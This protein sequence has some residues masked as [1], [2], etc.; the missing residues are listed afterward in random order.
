MVYASQNGSLGH[1]CRPWKVVATALEVQPR[2]SRRFSHLRALSNIPQHSLSSGQ[3]RLFCALEIRRLSGLGQYNTPNSANLQC[4]STNNSVHSI[5][6]HKCYSNRHRPVNKATCLIH[7]AMWT[8]S[9]S[10]LPAAA[11]VLPMMSDPAPLLANALAPSL[12]PDQDPG[13]DPALALRVLALPTTLLPGLLLQ[14][15]HKSRSAGAVRVP[16]MKAKRESPCL[17]QCLAEERMTT[18]GS[19]QRRLRPFLTCILWLPHHVYSLA[20]LFQFRSR[21]PRLSGLRCDGRI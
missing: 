17:F 7:T 6:T 1:P 16:K 9:S 11:V 4:N 8:T 5:P 14:R 18:Q 12:G 2:S 10:L 21:F 20:P 19:A 3:F 13:L 15:S